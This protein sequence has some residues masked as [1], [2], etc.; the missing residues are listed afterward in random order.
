MDEMGLPIRESLP[1]VVDQLNKYGLKGRIRVLASG[2]RITPSEVAWALCA[3]ADGVNNARGFMFALGC[4]QSL[5]CNRNTCP[6]GVATHDVK[7][8][9]GLHPGDKA[10]RVANYARNMMKEVAI[11]ANSCGVSEPR[12]LRRH[13]A[14][15]VTANGIS[16]PLS[17][18]FPDVNPDA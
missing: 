11:I 3:G 9:R 15:I 17:E 10:V 18:L 14:R 1:M 6:T 5:Q 16:V 12:K 13:H 7:L 8:Q 2:K 4:I